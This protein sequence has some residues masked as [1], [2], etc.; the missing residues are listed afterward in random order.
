MFLILEEILTSMKSTAAKPLVPENQI[1]TLRGFTAGKKTIVNGIINMNDFL[2]QHPQALLANLGI[3][4]WAP[5]L[6]YASEYLYNE[7]CCIS[8]I[9]IFL[10]ITSGGASEYMNILLFS[11]NNIQLLEAE[12]NHIVFWSPA[13]K[14]K[15]EMEEAGK[16][17]KDLGIDTFLRQ[18]LRLK[19]IRYEFGVAKRFPQQYLKILANVDAH[20]DDEK[21]PVANKYNIKKMEC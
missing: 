2:I 12:Y 21:D 20:N 9:Q 14:Y 7:A 8:A 5:D 4:Q 18:R 6:N 11:L 13:Q 3:C 17:K 19:N 1:I 10:Q 15:K 16:N